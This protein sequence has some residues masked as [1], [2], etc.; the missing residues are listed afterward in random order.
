MIS[1]CTGRK[2]SIPPILLASQATPSSDYPADTT[3]VSY[4]AVCCRKIPP[5]VKLEH[6]QRERER[7][8]IIMSISLTRRCSIH[9]MGGAV[10]LTYFLCLPLHPFAVSRVDLLSYPISPR[11]SANSTKHHLIKPPN[12]IGAKGQLGCTDPAELHHDRA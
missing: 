6:T 3:K 11:V 2:Y 4:P 10:M 9:S 5:T 1:R 7:G 8:S 12:G